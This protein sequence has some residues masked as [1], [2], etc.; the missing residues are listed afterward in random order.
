MSTV[1]AQIFMSYNQWLLNAIRELHGENNMVPGLSL[2]FAVVSSTDL[3][4]KM[5]NTVIDIF[6]MQTNQC[7]VIPTDCKHVR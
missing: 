7:I 2:P 4:V 1:S 6:N 3:P 5:N